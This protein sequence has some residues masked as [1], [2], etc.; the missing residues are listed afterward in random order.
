MLQVGCLVNEHRGQGGILAE[1]ERRNVTAC[2]SPVNFLWR[3][4]EEDSAAK[5]SMANNLASLYLST[6]V[7]AYPRTLP[8]V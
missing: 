7:P 8:A 3:S 2:T 1:L 4:C 6:D 5:R